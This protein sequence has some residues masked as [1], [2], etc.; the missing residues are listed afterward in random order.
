M[1]LIEKVLAKFGM[2]NCRGASAPLEVARENS[3]V[4]GDD[5]DFD[6]CTYRKT[7]GWLLYVSNVRRPDL[8]FA[9]G[10][11]SRKCSNPKLSDW[12]DVQHIF[13]YLRKTG[14]LKLRYS[15]TGKTPSVFCAASFVSDP[16]DGK[17]CS[18]YVLIL[19][20]GAVSWCSR[21]QSTV[22]SR[23]LPLNLNMLL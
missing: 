5:V 17:S 22:L 8:A 9:V 3:R 1:L 11:V 18:G 10:K 21:K 14:N 13:R 2:H 19:G 23:S 20:G 15:K 12:R 16:N 4:P 6:E 7:V